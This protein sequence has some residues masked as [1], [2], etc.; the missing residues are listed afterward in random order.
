M[1]QRDT[2]QTKSEPPTR[3]R[4]KDLRKRGEVAKS[5]DVTATTVLLAALAFF[6]LA[7][8]QL[9]RRLNA[10][11]EQVVGLPLTDGDDTRA[12]GAMTRELL[13]DAA[14]LIA[15]LVVVVIIAAALS[16][17]LQ[18]GPVFSTD[19]IKPQ[20]ERLNPVAGARRMFS[21]RTLV[22]LIKLFIKTGVLALIVWLIGMAL[23]PTLL[24]APSLDFRAVLPL[25][26]DSVWRLVAA[27]LV[28]F[29]AITA[30][31]VWFQR[32]D[33]RRRN[34]MSLDEVRR[35]NR[36]E[37]GD[38]HV[39]SRRRQ[40]HREASTASMLEGVRQA[41]VVIVNPTHFAVALHYEAG[42]TAL[43]V[44]VAKGEDDVARRIRAIAEEEGIPILHDVDL[45]RRLHA[46]APV[47]EYIP[48]EFIEP[49]AAVLR[50]VRELGTGSSDPST[51][52]SG[53][54]NPP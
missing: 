10:M 39:R 3:R 11:L 26:L 37:E 48:E 14:W 30:A 31:D 42:V 1:N 45:A 33:H 50:W 28:G 23:L 52:P 40:L 20:F 25:A 18:V 35:E 21:T 12:V 24:R 46:G 15:P 44:V 54:G 29:I 4:L 53:S 41:S 17:F 32:W 5:G 7:G 16:G 19:P 6:M 8:S 49:V 38:P 34:R 22:E 9:L 43:P 51:A 2:G 36:E 47:D 13:V 27:A